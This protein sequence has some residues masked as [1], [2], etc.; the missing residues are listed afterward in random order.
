MDA[1]EDRAGSWRRTA[2]H[3][4][5]RGLVAPIISLAVIWFVWWALVRGLHVAVYVACTPAQAFDAITQNWSTLS[6]LVW[7]TMR[8]TVYGLLIGTAC[9]A[10]FAIVMSRLRIV[11]LLLYPP[12]ITSQAVPI[13]ALA[14]ILVLIFNFTLTPIVMIVTLF[15]FFPIT[16]NTLGA[17]KAVDRDLLDLTRA[18]GAR[19][20]R[21]FA[22]IELPS[23]L[24]GFLSGLKIASVYAVSGA[25]IGQLYDTVNNASLAINQTRAVNDFRIPLVYGDTMLMTV[26]SLVMFLAAVAIGYLATPWLHRDVA[27]P[28]SRAGKTEPVP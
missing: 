10:V 21:R 11:E 27:R 26:L 14:P 15:V 28:W 17:L 2:G 1:P 9:G 4:L 6:P 18:L 19:R 23:A 8:E 5:V 3:P 22:F 24:P 25:I 7:A 13:I 20:W 12:I 16:V